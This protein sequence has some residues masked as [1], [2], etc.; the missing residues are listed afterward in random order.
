MGSLFLI[1]LV[2]AYPIQPAIVDISYE[3][4]QGNASRYGNF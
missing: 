1:L 3:L 4:G 2:N